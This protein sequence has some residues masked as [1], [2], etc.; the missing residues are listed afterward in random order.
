MRAEVIGRADVR[1]VA[2]G[3][4]LKQPPRNG[5][6]PKDVSEWT[7][8]QALG[9]GCLTPAGFVPRQLK[10][11]PDT[12]L[13]R[14][15]QLAD[16][17]LLM[18]RANTRELV[19]LVGRYTDTGAACIY[20]DLMMRLRVDP[21]KSLPEYVE[22]VLRSESLRRAI[23]AGARGTSDS[24]VKIGASFVRG[25]AIPLPALGEQQR[26]VAVHGAFER[27]ISTLQ[28]A[29][30]KREQVLS[31]LVEDLLRQ[32]RGNI[33]SLAAVRESCASGITLGAHR[34]PRRRV[35]GYLRVANVRKGWIDTADV[36]MVETESR[37]RPRYE[38]EAGDVLVVE[39]HANPEQIGRAAV[40][41]SQERGLLYQ[42][43]LFRLR[44]DDCLPEFAMLWLNSSVVRSYWRTRCSTS[45]GLYT[46]N[47]RLLDGVPFPRVGQCEQQRIVEAWRSA[48]SAIE[49]AKRQI[50]KLRT[51][52]MG[53]VEDL[54]GGEVRTP[55]A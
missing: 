7:G 39:G 44:F 41:G 2:L 11:V 27:R 46:I 24:M 13:A 31:A 14:Q 50:A 45:S 36:A 52:Q 28:R 48:E 34:A 37:D 16:G 35:S 32:H 6:S 47:S 54:L 12:A 3:T 8:L 53:V 5:Y 29:V 49:G 23:R 22:V 21:A 20:P 25:L 19:G 33:V 55:V 4:V 43:H 42:N 10:N 15:A 38:L 30:D 40:V 17:D 18:S 1:R 51:V 9:L 26:I